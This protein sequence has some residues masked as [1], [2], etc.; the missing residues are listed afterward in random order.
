MSYSD[1]ITINIIVSD[2]VFESVRN[3]LNNKQV[4]ELIATIAAINYAARFLKA[5][6]VREFERK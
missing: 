5:L 6:D 2:K 4:V 3:F 1:A